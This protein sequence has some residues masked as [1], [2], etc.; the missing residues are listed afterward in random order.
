MRFLCLYKPSRPEGTP[1]SPRDI[2]KMNKL[3]EQGMTSGTL[4][5]T[6]GCMPSVHGARVRLADGKY[7]V[8]DGP[9]SEAKELV[10]GMAIIEAKSKEDMIE[11]TRHFLQA[12]GDGETEIR[13]LYEP[14]APPCA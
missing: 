10:G 13:Q 6:G 2:E 5:A 4:I 14:D 12:A 11:Q 1:P 7:T 3:V 9:F 8:T